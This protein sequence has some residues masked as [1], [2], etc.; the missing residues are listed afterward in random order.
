MQF[1]NTVKE[2]KV[3]KTMLVILSIPIIVKV[4]YYINLAG[5]YFGT[6]LRYFISWIG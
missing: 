4:L 5:V 1:V 6:F 3:L 2:N